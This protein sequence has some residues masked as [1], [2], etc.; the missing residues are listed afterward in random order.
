[1]INKQ[2]IKLRKY[3]NDEI[4]KVAPSSCAY[5]DDEFFK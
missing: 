5:I 1:M 4:L 3:D 2:T